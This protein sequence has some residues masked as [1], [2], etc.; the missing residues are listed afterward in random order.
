MP[1]VVL[2]ACQGGSL[3]WGRLIESCPDGVCAPFCWEG[4][5]PRHER[6]VVGVLVIITVLALA[7]ATWGVVM[8]LAPLIQLRRMLR[9]GSSDDV[10][11]GYLVLL[12]PGFACGSATGSLPATPPWSSPILWQQS[13]AA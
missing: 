11:L 5:V 13:L 8:A 2:M 4:V 10:S 9:R 3:S 1:G 7:A 12:L 6:F